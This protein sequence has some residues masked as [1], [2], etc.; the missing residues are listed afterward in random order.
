[1]Y[2]RGLYVVRR[3]LLVRLFYCKYDGDNLRP[4][5]AS[6]IPHLCTVEGGFLLP[7]LCRYLAIVLESLQIQEL[8]TELSR[9]NP[10]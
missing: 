8:G 9:L 7:L 6:V 1:M 5:S 2:G 3:S 10:Q 4:G